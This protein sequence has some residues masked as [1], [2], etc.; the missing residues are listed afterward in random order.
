MKLVKGIVRQGEDDTPEFQISFLR[1][2]IMDSDIELVEDTEVYARISS[3]G[4][5]HVVKEV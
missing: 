2:H 4:F 5:V 3:E 1:L